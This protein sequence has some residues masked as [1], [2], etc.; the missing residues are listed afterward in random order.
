[1]FVAEAPAMAS[2]PR[3]ISGVAD[4]TLA[5]LEALENERPELG[6]LEVIDGALHASGGSSV[7]NLHQMLMQQLHLLFHAACP[8]GDIIRLDTW[9]LL[10]RGKLRPDVAVYRRG[11]QPEK[12]SGGFRVPPRA[13]VEIISEDSHHDLVRKDEIYAEAGVRR[14]YVN[15]LPRFDWWIR[16][17]GVDHAG[18]EA[19]WQLDGWPA[20]RLER[21]S[22]F[23]E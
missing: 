11:D 16:L 8:P 12:P 21:H 15:D 3:M 6:R 2:V 5:E 7:G 13:I 17:D 18:P 20:L 1:M 19:T 22:L 9:W 4:Y 23:T 10:D 14:A